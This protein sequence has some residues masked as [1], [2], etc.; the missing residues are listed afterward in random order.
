MEQ[1]SGIQA[2]GIWELGMWT[3]KLATS[4]GT[5]GA[6]SS[7]HNSPYSHHVYQ[8]ALVYICT[9][10]SPVLPLASGFTG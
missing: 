4:H 6:V 9:L 10:S 3:L 2:F 8:F 1:E 7:S 5:H